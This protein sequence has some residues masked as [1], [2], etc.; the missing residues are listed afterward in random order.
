MHNSSYIYLN[1]EGQLCIIDENENMQTLT[2]EGN[3]RALTILPNNN[4][5]LERNEGQ[6]GMDDYKTYTYNMETMQLLQTSNNYR[7]AYTK[8]M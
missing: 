2:D 8:Y 1:G 6:N 5:L 3:F 4:I 7:Y